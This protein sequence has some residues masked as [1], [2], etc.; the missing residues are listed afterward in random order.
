MVVAIA[1][2]LVDKTAGINFITVT[3]ECRSPII[4]LI[5]V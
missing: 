5:T 3:T 1:G 2:A 4:L